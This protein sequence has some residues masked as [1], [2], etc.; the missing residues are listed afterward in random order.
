MMGILER[1]ILKS[2]ASSDL[3]AVVDVSAHFDGA[4][5]RHHAEGV[6]YFNPSTANTEAGA[7]SS[8]VYRHRDFINRITYRPKDVLRY[9]SPLNAK[10]MRML[11]QATDHALTQPSGDWRRVRIKGNAPVLLRL[12][13]WTLKDIINKKKTDPYTARIIGMVALKLLIAAPLQLVLVSFPMGSSGS[14]TSYDPLLTRCWDYPKYARNQLD[15]QPLASTHVTYREQGFDFAGEHARQLKPRRLVVLR[16]DE[17]FIEEDSSLPYVVISYTRD[18]FVPENPRSCQGLYR[19]AEKV[20]SDAGLRAYW[21]DHHCITQERCAE[22]TDDIHRICDVIRG[23]RQIAVAVP[24]LNLA[25]LAQWGNRMWTLSEALLSRN[26][27]I[28]FCAVDG[29]Y[30]EMDRISLANDVWENDQAGRL[31]A[32]HFSKN[33]TLSRLELV[34]LGI[35]ALSARKTQALYADADL[36]YALMGLLNHRPRANPYDNLFQALARLS[37]AND[38][39][40]IVERMMCMLPDTEA[41]DRRSNKKFVLKDK[42]GANLWDIEPLCQVAGVCEGSA[43]ILDGCR[44]ATIVWKEIPRIAYVTR[45]SMKRT[46]MTAA[47]RSGGVIPLTG[48]GLLV[49]N[50][51]AL[52]AVILILGLLLLLSSPW[53]INMLYGGKVWGAEP[54]LIGFEGVLPIRELE[55][56][57]FGNASGRI[58]YAPSSSAIAH[59][60]ERER[61]GKEPDWVRGRGPIEL[62]VPPGQR[63]FTLVDTGSLTVSLFTAE[64]PPSMALIAGREGGM[65]R[66]VLCHYERS[67]ATLQKETVLRMETPMM[68]KA[69]QSIFHVICPAANPTIFQDCWVG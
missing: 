46:I 66:V 49:A 37:L 48:I 54:W 36:A 7:T 45:K 4:T 2:D 64:K 32:E 52:G 28:K 38:S 53:S 1:V 67:T 11:V 29:T 15:A 25:T 17:W 65:L 9:I 26:D 47:M 39:D 57:M 3:D 21:L 42:L 44:G 51:E 55:T 68:N 60:H 20:T 27:L 5:H 12:S 24:N 18:H 6:T 41:D 16:G 30:V 22:R 56:L 35:Q 31:L 23:A 33:L 58:S 43:V 50:Q 8:Q 10:P 69:G 13:T 19:V 40:R 61:L 62:P 14:K 34:S 63:L 59:K